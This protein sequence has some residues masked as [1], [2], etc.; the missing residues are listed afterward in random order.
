MNI[1]KI[2][3]LLCASLGLFSCKS[4]V[5][6]P[7][8]PLENYIKVYMPLAVNNPVGKTLGVADTLQTI[9]FGA[10]FGGQDYPT[11]DIAL[12]FKVNPDV[13]DSFNTAN[14]TSYELL[15]SSGYTLSATEA[16]IPKGKLNTAPLYISVKTKGAGAINALQ[17]YI[18]P[19]SIESSTI[20]VNENL[21]TTFYVVK[22]QP[23]LEDYTDY[24]RALW[25]V[26]GFSSQEANGEGANNGRAIH[27]ID[28]DKTTFW[29]SQWQGG[30][31]GPPHHIIY[32]MGEE[33]EVHGLSFLSRQSGDNGKPNLV[34]IETSTDNVTWT[35]GGNVE[36]QNNNNLQRRF[37]SSF[38]QAR[39]VKIIITS[40][41]SASHSHLAELYAF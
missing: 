27:S 34:T 23:D 12:K 24:D 22:S 17:N 40:S 5:E 2:Y 15:P 33:K 28:G 41:F 13:I 3:L 39:Y 32:D 4:E 31:P 16:T 26:A 14:G 6:L 29:H 21:R 8:Q 35:S 11:K 1:R 25:S 36:L 9:V 30:S 37:L 20:N 19:I 38:R 18:L 7:D 10:C